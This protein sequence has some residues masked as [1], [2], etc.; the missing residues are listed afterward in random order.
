ME[1]QKYYKAAIG[2]KNA[3]FYLSRFHHFDSNGVR[4]SW[5]WPAFFFTFYWLLYRKMG[6]FA[7]VYVLLPIPLAAIDSIRMIASAAPIGQLFTAP[8]CFWIKLPIIAPSG[9]PSSAGVI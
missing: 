7:L 4:P 9:P 1:V 3:D 2:E 6:L 8:N 5:N